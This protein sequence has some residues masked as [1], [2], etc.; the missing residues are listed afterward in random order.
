MSA[1]PRFRLKTMLIV[2]ALVALWLSTFTG[3]AA[4]G[5]VRRSMVL[6]TLV[7]SI[8]AAYCSD[9]SQKAFWL[10]FAIVIVPM[11]GGI[12][13]YSPEMP[14]PNFFWTTNLF[15]RP[16]TPL[17]SAITE[18]IRAVGA[19]LLATIAGFIGVYIYSQTRKSDDT[20]R[21]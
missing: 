4:G 11:G 10:C 6:L 13:Y 20:N 14:I 3:Y 18:T 12:Y 15:S 7:A 1:M 16:A 5:D 8:F 21:P 19:L 9:G 17:G 2:F